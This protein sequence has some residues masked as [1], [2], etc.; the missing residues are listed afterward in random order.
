MR[1]ILSKSSRGHCRSGALQTPF[2]RPPASDFP[3]CPPAPA[4]F[5]LLVKIHA[6]HRDGKRIRDKRIFC[7]FIRQ[8]VV[9]CAAVV[10]IVILKNAPLLQLIL[11]FPAEKHL[12]KGGAKL[13]YVVADPE[14]F[15]L[16]CVFI[17]QRGQLLFKKRHLFLGNPC[18]GRLCLASCHDP[19]SFLHHK[20]T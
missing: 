19:T 4:H 12:R 13:R 11:V 9:L 1:A 20:I 16:R 18:E 6:D 7:L 2:L 14:R 15:F 3:H 10:K 8:C 5:P 17:R